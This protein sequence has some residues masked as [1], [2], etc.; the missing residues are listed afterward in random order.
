MPPKESPSEFN[1]LKVV[2]IEED[3]AMR[4]L[5][6]EWLVGEG[7]EVRAVSPVDASRGENDLSAELVIVDLVN[8]RSQGVKEIG[9]IQRR[10]P[11]ARV[12]GMSTQVG[13]SLS[14][15]SE[16]LRGLGLVRLL[17]KPCEREELLEAVAEASAVR[18]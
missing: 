12:I 2:V 8:L 5:I 1:M 9:A 17:A 18:N 13:R 15:N 3:I 6:G 10:F 14:G 4:A 11:C 7:Y 16:A